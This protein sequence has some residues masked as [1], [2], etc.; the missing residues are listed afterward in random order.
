[1][2]AGRAGVGAGVRAA[3]PAAAS[4]LDDVVHLDDFRL[5]R[6]DAELGED[7][8]EALTECAHLLG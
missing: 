4:A 5:S 2:T 8:S 1:M 7:R 3:R 6:V